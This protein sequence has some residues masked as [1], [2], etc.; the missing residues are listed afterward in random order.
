[1]A[2]KKAKG[3]KMPMMSKSMPKSMS[4]GMPKKGKGKGG[5]GC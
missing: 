4:K 5:K 1:M 3:Y 2:A